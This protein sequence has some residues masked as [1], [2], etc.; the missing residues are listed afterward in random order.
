MNIKRLILATIVCISASHA[1]GNI[2][3]GPS[4][5]VP[6]AVPD[7]IS[8]D[9]QNLQS[10]GIEPSQSPNN[11]QSICEAD[12]WKIFTAS[13]IIG[14]PNDNGWKTLYVRF[15]FE[16]QSPYWGSI[17][18]NPMDAIIN[19]ED[20][21]QYR[22]DNESYVEKFQH[23]TRTQKVDLGLIPP[24]F[25]VIGLPEK[26]AYL[27][28]TQAVFEVAA[29]QDSFKLTLPSG[30]I[31]CIRDGT[32]E[33][34][35]LGL[36]T[37]DL[38]KEFIQPST[39]TIDYENLQ[40]LTDEITLPNL[41]ILNFEDYMLDKI[42]GYDQALLKLQ[43]QFM[44]ASGGYDANPD[45]RGYFIGN[46]GLVRGFFTWAIDTG[47]VCPQHTVGPGLTKELALCTFIPDRIS[48]IAFVI[49]QP[50]M[51]VF[52]LETIP[53]TTLNPYP[54]QGVLKGTILERSG[55]PYTVVMTVNDCSQNNQCASISY[56][57]YPCN[58]IL[59]FSGIEDERYVFSE[60]MIDG[61][62]VDGGSI[63][64]RPHI[65]DGIWSWTWFYPEG[66]PGDT[67]L[68]QKN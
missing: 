33:Y 34:D 48:N 46:D 54:P 6:S 53:A 68:L 32:N 39:P 56:L 4:L 15:G 40:V 26:E 50:I 49:T 17:D 65:L 64:I 44:N 1:C 24:G 20:G 43:F 52:R 31:T 42:F 3:T 59:T 67:G 7:Q 38:D 11:A 9:T 2:N 22:A 41:G 37:Y 12:K 35:Q 47:D 13:V 57:D 14:P 5:Q 16:N 28:Y 18:I 10:S 29:N 27:G 19:T 51:A 58:S 66:Y 63:Q 55:R 8:T 21:F 36:V 25:V 23:M 61:S 45:I 30:N 62:C 60:T